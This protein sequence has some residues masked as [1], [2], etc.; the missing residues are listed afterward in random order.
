V[1]TYTH[2]SGRERVV[3]VPGSAEDQRLSTAEDWTT[4]TAQLEPE[5]EPEREESE[6]GYPA[7]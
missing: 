3:T 5:P 4:G 1:P 2:E 7:E 6:H